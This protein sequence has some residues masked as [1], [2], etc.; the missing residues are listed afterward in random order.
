MYL[1][2]RQVKANVCEV[3]VNP[4]SQARMYEEGHFF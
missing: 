3:L 2:S 1:E 4:N